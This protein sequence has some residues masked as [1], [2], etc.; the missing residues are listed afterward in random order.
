MRVLVALVLVLGAGVPRASAAPLGQGSDF[1]IPTA[2]S[3]PEGIAA[4]PDGNL[5]FTEYSAGK[6]GEL[7]PSTHAINE[8]PIPTAGTSP[9]GIAL[10]PDGN[11]WFTEQAGKIG[12]INPTTHVISEFPIPTAGTSP[13]GI[14]LGP[15]GNLWF[16]E[17]GA[18]KIGEINPTTHVISESPA[19]TAYSGP[20][21]IAT[22]PDGNLWF[23]E[24]QASKIGEINPT[25]HATTD[26]PTP[27]ATSDPEVIALGPDGNLWFT[28]SVGKIGEINPATHATSDVPT[29]TQQSYPEGI[30][31]GPDGNLWFTEL[32]GSR[33]GELNPA[34]RAISEFPAPTAA[35][36]PAYIA[37]G[38]DG[39]LWFTEPGADKIGEIG[40]NAPAASVAAPLVS[41]SAQQG[42]QQQCGGDRW[43]NWAGQQPLA[44]AF[45][46]DGY[47]WLLDGA[48]V[49]GG[50]FYTPT[51]AN[52]GHQLS[53]SVTVT[54]PLLATTTSA[55]SQPVTVIPPGP[56]G[57]QGP[58]GRQG[59][60]GAR[61]PAGEV[62]LVTCTTTTHTAVKTVNGKRRTV[63]VT[64]QACQTKLVP[65][66]VNFPA[67]NAAD[68]EAS[69]S[70]AR[71]VYAT[72][73]AYHS[74]LGRGQIR[75]LAARPIPSGRY[76]LALTTHTRG[77]RQI[78]RYQVT[79]R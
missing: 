23:T 40:A 62:E 22:G 15:D 13:I 33:I 16:T 32:N 35:G 60:P 50:Q 12:E 70:R 45:G 43:S 30:V 19:P 71:V 74:L 24:Y 65:G 2:N 79:V 53:C 49:A 44:D 10:G 27:T 68:A 18:S 34:T 55:S 14:A 9:I 5:W 25:T 7:N 26:F 57:S 29:P 76:T 38:P 11:L 46:F 21:G 66:P 20:G 78:T 8:F 39:N 56:P 73:Y 58:P 3:F 64:Q 4:G 75:L 63:K 28:E 17:P 54:Y 59:S 48:P 31:A 6:I 42:T 77:R 61:G 72:G 37:V 36:D 67:Q 1:A 41:G 51:P 69:L 52:I 47:R